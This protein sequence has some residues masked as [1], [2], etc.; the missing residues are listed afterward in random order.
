MNLTEII[1]TLCKEKE[2]MK[3]YVPLDNLH[4]W[5]IINVDYLETLGFVQ[6]G[7][8]MMTLNKPSLT[9]FLKRDGKFHLIDKDKKEHKIFNKFDDVMVYFD[10]YKQ[11]FGL[12]GSDSEDS[13]IKF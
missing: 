5:N 3:E 13:K 8:F 11:D 12:S 6:D 9:L 10:D 4:L 2:N 1:H 7:N